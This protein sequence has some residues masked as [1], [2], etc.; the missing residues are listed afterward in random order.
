M[1]AEFQ[2]ELKVTKS[3]R[4]RDMMKYPSQEEILEQTHDELESGLQKKIGSIGHRV[5]L[6]AGKCN[7]T[8]Q[9]N[10]RVTRGHLLG[11]TEDL[12]GGFWGERRAEEGGGVYYISGVSVLTDRL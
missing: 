3:Q 4:I 1:L 10:Q 6:I 9:E 11:H 2:E 7:T 8:I 5:D 12:F